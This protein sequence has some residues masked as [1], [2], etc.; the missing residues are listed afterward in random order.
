M[1]DL[2][3]QTFGRLVAKEYLKGSKWKCICSC[4]KEVIV[5]TADLRRG[6]TQ[7]CGC[8]QRERTSTAS[9]KNLIGEKFGYLEVLER[10][11][12]YVGKQVDLRW[13]CRCEKCGQIKSIRAGSLR[14]GVISCGCTRQS[15]GEYKIMSIL[16]QYH[17]PFVSEF[18]FS[19][20]R[21]KRYDFAILNKSGAPIRLIEF[22]GLQH[23]YRPRANHWS[24]SSSLEETKARDEEKNQIAKQKGIQLI[25][26]PY[27]HIDDI[28]IITL[29]DDT[30]LLKED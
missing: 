10:D 27:W 29:L 16:K 12:N 1:I 18:S 13:I 21:D 26:I 15:R 7:S 23:Y 25:R 30:Y 17:I 28:S 2:T 6:H 20:N 14:Q 9:V 11:M 19:D 5:S 4:G 24:A 22:D 3:N 8:L